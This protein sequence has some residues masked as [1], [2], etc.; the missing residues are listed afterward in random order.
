M[1]EAGLLWRGE[2]FLRVQRGCQAHVAE[3]GVGGLLAE[4]GLVGLPA[5]AAGGHGAAF[6]IPDHVEAAR[7]AVL[8]VVAG[9]GE[10]FERGLVDGFEEA[11]AEDS[12]GEAGAGEEVRAGV[13]IAPVSEGEAGF[14]EGGG[15]A[16]GVGERG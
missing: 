16:V 14:A 15:G 12:R 13:A 1:G 4:A 9:V 5:E 3:E 11:A 7:D 8:V 10:V 2:V 6:L